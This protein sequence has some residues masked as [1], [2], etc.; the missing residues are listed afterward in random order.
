MHPLH[1]QGGKLTI[2]SN[3][4]R[5]GIAQTM[6]LT[7]VLGVH[8]LA[9]EQPLPH[10]SKFATAVRTLVRRY[11]P[12]ATVTATDTTVTFEF[13]AM[14][15]MVHLPWKTGQWQ[16]ARAERGP[17]WPDGIVGSMTLQRGE[18]RGAAG[19]PQTF[20]QCY[21]QR[22]VM[23]SPYSRTFDCHLHVTLRYPASPNPDVQATGL[24]PDFLAAF[25]TLVNEVEQYLE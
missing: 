20:H 15:F 21:F 4:A 16:A 11:Y 25:T 24:D 22:L 13:N 14:D 7:L 3:Y 17:Q 2:M 8:A 19:L 9:A 5:Y 6:V 10:L 1:G 18:Y 12:Q 23:V